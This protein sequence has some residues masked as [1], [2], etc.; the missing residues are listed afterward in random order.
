MLGGSV[1]GSQFSYHCAAGPRE[2]TVSAL[3]PTRPCCLLARC[4]LFCA[5]PWTRVL[6]ISVQHHP[7]SL[8][9][10][11]P[12]QVPASC[13]ASCVPCSSLCDSLSLMPFFRRKT[14]RPRLTP[15]SH[16]LPLQ[17]RL[18]ASWGQWGRTAA[19]VCNFWRQL[20]TLL[21]TCCA[22]FI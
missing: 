9:Y 14:R 12:S 11:T 2:P 22:L 4:S 5:L 20:A 10:S 8:L 13:L 17:P 15:C 7:H 1:S 16:H 3:K 18:V 19:R 6:H 21:T